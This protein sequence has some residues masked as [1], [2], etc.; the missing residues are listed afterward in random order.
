MA[1]LYADEHFP[2][3]V[4]EELRRLGHDVTTVQETGHAGLKWPDSEVLKDATERGRALLTLNRRDFIRLHGENPNHAGVIAC[5]QNL[6]FVDLAKR[7]DAAIHAETTLAG[8]V[9]RVY[10]PQS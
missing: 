5:T 4:V 6:D 7:I 3:P 8:R 1:L 2:A 9:I 10:R